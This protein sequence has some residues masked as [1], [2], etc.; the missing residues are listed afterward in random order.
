M[1]LGQVVSGLK[2]ERDLL[3]RA[4]AVLEEI[5]GRQPRGGKIPKT[6]STTQTSGKRRV[7]SAAGKRRISEAMKK[8][9]AERRAK[10]T[11]ARKSANTA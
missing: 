11:P 5:D 4:I 7:L 3:D 1:N 10:L 6:S 8:R 2:K 9:W